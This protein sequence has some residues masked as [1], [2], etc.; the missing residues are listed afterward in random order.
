MSEII[1]GMPFEEYAARPGVNASLLKIVHK[2]SMMH[3]RAYLDG[4]WKEESNALDF[5]KCFHSLALEGREDFVEIPATYLSDKNEEKPWN[6]NANACKKWGEEQGEKFTLKSGEVMAVRSMADAARRELGDA[7][8]G[9]AEV[10]LFTEIKGVPVKCR[11]DLLP[12]DCN[13]PICDLKSCASSEPA[14]FVRNALDLGYHLQAAF[15]LDVVHACGLPHQEFNLVAIE[16]EAPHAPCRIRFQDDHLTLL[17]V[18]RMHYRSAFKNLIEAQ[19]TGRWFGYGT[20]AAE[21]YTPAWLKPELEQ[22]A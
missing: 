20:V 19:E 16:S 4:L 1:E 11:I 13:E 8:K 15:T 3:A 2:K 22:T 17:R 9:R 10:S 5:G 12:D 14:K 18:G 21:D 7:L 6:W